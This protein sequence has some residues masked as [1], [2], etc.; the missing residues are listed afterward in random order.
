MTSPNTMIL[1][2]K[3][4]LCPRIGVVTEHHLK[5]TCDDCFCLPTMAFCCW[6]FEL[7]SSSFED[8]PVLCCCCCGSSN[9]PLERCAVLTVRTTEETFTSSGSD[10]R[11][12]CF[13]LAGTSVLPAMLFTMALAEGQSAEDLMGVKQADLTEPRDKILTTDRSTSVHTQVRLIQQK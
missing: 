9:G 10:S 3:V 5:N 8:P 13:F 2:S 7:W 4:T 6:R 12:F 1:S 11:F